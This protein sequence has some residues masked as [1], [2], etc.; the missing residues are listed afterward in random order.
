MIGH[1][2]LGFYSAF[3]VADEVQIDTLSYKE[4]A[5]PVHWASQGGTEYEMQEGN[6]TTVGSEITLFLNE[7]SL[8]FANEYRAREVL[9]RY[10]SFMPVEIFLS[11][12]NA[13]P[14]Y[15][16]IDEA[17]VLDTDTVVEHITEHYTIEELAERFEISPT[18][19]KK[20]FKEMY[21]VPIYTYCRTYRLQ[22]AEKMLREGQL[23]VAEIAAKIGYINPNKFTSAF[24]SEYKMTPTEYKKNVQMDRK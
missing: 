1:F 22:I 14:E 21:G 8:E 18:S 9:E 7:D 24:C 6:K 20:C 15:D 12:A 23:S 17:D 2:G 10:C 3:M 11:K 16:T 5:K 13:E 19:L 4:G